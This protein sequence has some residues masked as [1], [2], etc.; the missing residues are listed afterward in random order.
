MDFHTTTHIKSS[1]KQRRCVL[2]G[3]LLPV[4]AP[5]VRMT[6]VADSDFYTVAAHPEV[7]PLYE[8]FN[9]LEWKECGACLTFDGFMDHLLESRRDPDVLAALETINRLKNNVTGI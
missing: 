7:V 6:G 4:G 9:N 3:I 5:Y 8:H 2:S 1:R